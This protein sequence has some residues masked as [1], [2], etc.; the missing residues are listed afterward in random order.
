MI[1]GAEMVQRIKMAKGQNTQS[2][3]RGSVLI[4]LG[5]NVN[6]IYAVSNRKI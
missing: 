6:I 1:I 4:L 2:F 3:I 5:S